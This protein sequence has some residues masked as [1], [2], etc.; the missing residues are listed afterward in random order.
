MLQ[1]VVTHA[2]QGLQSRVHQH[3]LIAG[4][5]CAWTHLAPAESSVNL[6]RKLSWLRWLLA[7]SMELTR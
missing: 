5:E 3:D 2:V 1:T 7:L 4:S 6:L